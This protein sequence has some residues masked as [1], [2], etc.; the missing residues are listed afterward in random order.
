MKILHGSI[1]GNSSCNLADI[2]LEPR[3]VKTL[4]L[5]CPSLP[6]RLRRV[7]KRF[8]ECFSDERLT[9]ILPQTFESLGLYYGNPFT[10]CHYGDVESVW[11]MLVHGVDSHIVDHVCCP[12]NP[13][14]P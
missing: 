13:D 4:C 1:M 12:R 5:V 3:I 2:V 10:Y 8:I 7:S 11:M 9:E 14:T 6:V